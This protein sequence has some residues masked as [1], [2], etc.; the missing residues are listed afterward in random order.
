MYFSSRSEAGLQLAQQLLRYRYENCAVLC[1]N[2]GAVL[3]GEQIAAKLHCVLMMLLTEEIDVPG[4]QTLFG[5]VDQAGGFVYNG[6]FSTGE[7]DDYYSEFHGFLEDQKREKFQHINRIL[8]QGGLLDESQ[9]RDHNVI[10]VS[11]GFPSGSSLDA[12]A[13]FLKH[14]RIKKLIIATPVASVQA[15]DRMHVLG[16]ELHVLSV[17][18]NYMDTDHYYEINQIP[19]H[20]KTLELINQIV[21]NWR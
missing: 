17:T 7:I 13:E 21:L 2:D 20:Q 12:A 18:D 1:L 15:V 19:D 14:L 10:L 11:D 6:M 5:T 16:D 3:V 9:L 4:E 8:G